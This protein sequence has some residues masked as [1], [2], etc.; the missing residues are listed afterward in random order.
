MNYDEQIRKLQMQINDLRTRMGSMSNSYGWIGSAW[1]KNPLLMGYSGVVR[2]QQSDTNLD[3]GTNTLDSDTVPAGEVWVLTN[4][5]YRYVGTVTNC[6]L[7]VT[8]YDGSTATYLSSK[9]AGTVASALFYNVEGPIVL[10]AGEKIRLTVFTA[11]ATDD[12]TLHISG[13]KFDID[14]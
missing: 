2:D 14:Q 4:I 13:Y 8:I 7:Y 12:C 3:A 11:T 10:A 9:A 1:H 5:S 6:S